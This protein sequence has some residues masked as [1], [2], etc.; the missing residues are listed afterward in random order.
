[1]SQPKTVHVLLV[2][3]D[4]VDVM[5][6]RR[7]FRE[8]KI[9]N[10]LR[11]ARDGVEA[12]SILRGTDGESPIARPYMILLDLN[13]PR[14]NGIEF[15]EEL[16]A[17]PDHHSA[18][19]MVLTTSD[20]D[21]DRMAAYDQHVAGYIIKSDIGGGFTALVDMLDHYWKVVEFP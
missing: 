13:M 16:R 19:V 7:A 18:I 1:M 2:E 8:R 11:V 10:P 15:L 14:M 5:A 21:R 20:E 12:L 3:D 4:E 17:D 9:A 6:V